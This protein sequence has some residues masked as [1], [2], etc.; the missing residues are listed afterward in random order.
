LNFN[1]HKKLND[2]NFLTINWQASKSF[3]KHSCNFDQI[4]RL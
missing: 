4:H 2:L 3:L 1:H